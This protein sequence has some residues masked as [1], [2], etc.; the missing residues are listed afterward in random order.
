MENKREFWVDNVKVVACLLVLLGHLMQSM[1]S[2]SIIPS[3]GF[4]NWFNKTVYHFHVPLFFICSGYLYQ[5]ICRIDKFTDWAKNSLKKLLNLGV[6]YV[7]FT[8]AVWLVKAVFSGYGNNEMGGLL[9]A[10]FLKP[11]APYWYLY[12]LFFIFLITVPFRNKYWALISVCLALVMKVISISEI[13]S[14]IYIYILST[15]FS[16]EIWFVAGMLICVM[17]IPEKINKNTVFA[18]TGIAFIVF[19]VL[20]VKLDIDFVGMSF[21]MGLLACFSVI[22]LFIAADKKNEN[23]GNPIMVWLSKYTMPIFLMHSIFA[24]ALRSVLLKIGITSAWIHIPAGIAIS[25][26]GPVLAAIVMKKLK[27]PEFLLYPSKFIKIK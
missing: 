13:G 22:G 20:V 10:V 7:A 14:N 9:E 19:S 12:C 6:P 21:M 25:I 11:T 17:D 1:A 23:S 5:K 4:Y 26:A 15:V 24:A 2:A 16:N 8:V 3:D 18:C 27:Y